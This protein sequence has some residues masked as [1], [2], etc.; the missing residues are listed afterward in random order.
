MLQENYLESQ[1]ISAKHVNGVGKES[2]FLDFPYFKTTKQLP[3]CSSHDFLEGCSKKWLLII[4]EHFVAE[5]WFSWDGLERM[6]KHFPFKGKDS[7]NRPA[8]LRAKKMATEISH[9]V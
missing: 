6:I 2:L 1:Q 8:I 7:T 5:K 4:L 9:K 3:Q